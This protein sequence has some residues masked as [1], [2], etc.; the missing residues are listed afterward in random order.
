MIQFLV[1]GLWSLVLETRNQRRR[2]RDPHST[3]SGFIGV[4]PWVQI[5]LLTGL[6]VCALLA[7]SA[8]ADPRTDY[9]LNCR[10][11]H[12]PDGSGLP[13]GGGAPSFRGQVG[14]FL[15][16]PGGREYL[17]RVP[18]TAQSELSDARIAAVLTWIVREFSPGEVPTDF[19]PFSAE[20]VGRYRRPP[21]AEVEGVR[22]GLLRGI[23]AH[24]AAAGPAV[25]ATQRQLP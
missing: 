18:G 2:T 21:L 9:I 20:E 4:H 10:G 5:S 8:V 23:A 13:D 6:A 11:C 12:A 14:K 17:I 25:P 15:W 3:P 16:V 22:R 24:A 19:A 1:C 7:S